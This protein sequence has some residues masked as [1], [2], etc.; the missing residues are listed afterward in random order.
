[1]IRY[2]RMRG[3]AA[4]WVPG[5]DHAGIATQLQVEKMLRDE[6]TSREEVG[7][8]EFLRRTWEWKSKYG[9]RIVAAASPPGRKLRLGSRALHAGRRAVAAPCAKPSC[10][11]R[12][13]PDL[14]RRHA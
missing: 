2:E 11:V 13:G 9:G 4:L 12:A 6:G 1:M 3:K 5:T 14:S 7:R 8:E 10:A